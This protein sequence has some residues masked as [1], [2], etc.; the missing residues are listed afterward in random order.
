MLPSPLRCCGHSVV[1]LFLKMAFAS[2]KDMG[3]VDCSSLLPHFGQPVH[4]LLGSH[5]TVGRDVDSWSTS[6]LAPTPQW[7]EMW[8]AGPLP[9]WLPH[10][11]GKRCGQLVHFL[12]GSHTTVGRDLLEG[13]SVVQ[14]QLLSNVAKDLLLSWELETVQGG[15]TV[16][17]EYCDR[18]P[19][20]YGMNEAL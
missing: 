17:R 8:T 6:S 19:H 14:G 13:H 10:H 18:K 12:I 20:L 2:L 11:S 5:T 1:K 4:I 3:C 7:E 9:H 16:C 15:L